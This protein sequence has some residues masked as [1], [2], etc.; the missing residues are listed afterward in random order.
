MN[1]NQPEKKE[2][3][4][5]EKS[6]EKK[7]SNQTESAE[8]RKSYYYDDAHGYEVYQPQQDDGEKD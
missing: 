1:E 2:Q 6:K 5:A 7:S 3:K 4:Q 8:N